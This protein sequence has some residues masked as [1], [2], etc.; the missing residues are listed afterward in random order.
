M[1]LILDALRKSEAER[2]RG[3]APDL[4]AELPPLVPRAAARR[5]AWPWW[6]AG[7]LAVLA[8][9]WMLRDV[10]SLAGATTAPAADA[11]APIAAPQPET[12]PVAI[13]AQAPI[14]MPTA[15]PPAMPAT[16][17]AVI[18]PAPVP[19]ADAAVREPAMP[20]ATTTAEPPLAASEPVTEPVLAPPQPSPVQV[21]SASP[22][23]ATAAPVA[24]PATAPAPL[25][26]ADLSAGEREQLPALKISMHMWGP[27]PDQRFA[28]IDGARVGQ[29]D[30]VGD[31]VVE[32]IGAD[33]VVLSW[34]GQRLALPIR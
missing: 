19:I 25:R 26:L 22:P 8:T 2:R 29:G 14:A 30:R 23:P 11:A 9:L 34:H 5:P 13:A 3:Q 15:V 20:A 32:E 21:A 1:S 16:T 31:A 27:T 33:S 4:Y 12:A 17:T 6:L 10:Q 28:I 24:A 7:G 18:A